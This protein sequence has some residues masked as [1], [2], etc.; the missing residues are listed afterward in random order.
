[1]DGSVTDPYICCLCGETVLVRD[2][3]RLSVST[4]EMGDQRQVLYAHKRC[5]A[6]SVIPQVPLH[7]D[8]L[9]D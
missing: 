3:V 6:D 4:D 9:S 2:V 1:M 7:P 8:L 5:F